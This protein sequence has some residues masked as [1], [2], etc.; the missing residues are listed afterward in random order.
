MFIVHVSWHS[1]P[2]LGFCTANFSIQTMLPMA[3]CLFSLSLPLQGTLQHCKHRLHFHH[4]KPSKG[5]TTQKKRKYAHSCVCTIRPELLQN[6]KAGTQAL[7]VPADLV[8]LNWKAS[9]PSPADPDEKKSM[10]T[11]SLAHLLPLSWAEDS[12]SQR[13]TLHNFLGWLPKAI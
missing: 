5:N 9:I 12:S 1:L 4:I 13:T 8:K 3:I 2:L 6:F 7:A 11:P 10:A